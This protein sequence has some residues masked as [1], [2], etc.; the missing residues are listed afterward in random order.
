MKINTSFSS[1]YTDRSIVDVRFLIF[2]YTGCSLEKTIEIF[3]NSPSKVSSHF[4]IDSKGEVYEMI[5]CLEKGPFKA[6]HA[7]KSYWKDSGGKL[8][9]DL[10]SYSLGV[11]LVNNNGNLFSY[12]AK[13]YQSLV[14][15]ALLLKKKFNFLESAESV[16]GHEHIASFRGKVDPGL[17]FDWKYFFG[18]AYGISSDDY[19]QRPP[20]LPRE[21]KERFQDLLKNWNSEEK[22]WPE[23]NLLM[24]DQC[25][26]YMK[27]K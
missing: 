15:L 2:H 18:K 8:W 16:L 3:Q 1:P 24:E 25:R 19:P 5:S 22:D 13:Q 26:H 11:E 10:N 20:Q 9:E 6:Y 12:T 27:T 14:E 4:V 21:I 7:G 23:F 17:Q